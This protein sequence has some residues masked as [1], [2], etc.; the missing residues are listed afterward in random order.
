QQNT[1]HKTGLRRFSSL[2]TAVVSSE[3]LRSGISKLGF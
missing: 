1:N 3:S 2:Q